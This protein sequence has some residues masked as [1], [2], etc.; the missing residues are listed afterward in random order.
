MK[1][2]RQLGHAIYNMDNPREVRRYWVFRA[3]AFLHRGKLRDLERFFA[4]DEILQ[5]IAETCPFVYEQPTRAFFYCKSN[6][7]SRLRIVQEHMTFLKEKLRSEIFQGL[8]DHKYYTLWED[9][10]EGELP[11]CCKHCDTLIFVLSCFYTVRHC[12]SPIINIILEILFLFL[13]LLYLLHH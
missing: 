11:L 13:K 6:F 2:F 12:N 1:S 7:D 4:S 3:R 5:A 10:A 8:Y 9:S